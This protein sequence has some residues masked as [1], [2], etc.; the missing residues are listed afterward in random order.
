MNTLPRE[1][2]IASLLIDLEAAL[3]VAGLWEQSA[4][5]AK[6]L[7]SV[8]PFCVDTLEF[9]QWLQFVFLPRMSALISAGEPLPERSGI[10]EMA[11]MWFQGRRPPSGPSVVA[12]LREIDIAIGRAPG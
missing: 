10:A 9:P 3:R 11:E 7:A 5:D 1:Y 4:P 2:R 12:V 6:A 8:E